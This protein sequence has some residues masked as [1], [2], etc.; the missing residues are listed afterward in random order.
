[1]N[2]GGLRIGFAGTPG[3]AATILRAL[4]THA[5]HSVTRVYS[6]P[7]RHSG[8]GRRLQPSAVAV[9]AREHGLNLQQPTRAAD[10]D[11]TGLAHLD[12]LAVAAF[13]LLLP[14]A[15]L[16]AP[17]LGCINVHASLLP[18]W[19]GAAP[20]QRAILAGD[21]CTGISIMQM[22]EGLDTG[23]VLL[24]K[25]CAIGADESAGQ[26]QERL[27]L[28]GAECLIEALAALAADTARRTPQDATAASYARKIRK[29]E[30]VIDWTMDAEQ[31]A[32]QVRA[33]NPVPIASTRLAGLELRIWEAQPVPRTENVPPGTLLRGD[34]SG[35][36]V[37][38][39]SGAVRITRLQLPGRRPVTAADFLNAHPDWRAAAAP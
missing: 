34:R 1:M 39:G 27:A 4:L 10:I 31:I 5:Q 33:F 22:D 15:L 35:I 8:R 6:L 19:R 9:L 11:A 2:P 36:D 7:D 13:G 12:V 38:A 16:H 37:A 23:D 18:R 20:I 30:A 32:R 21:A 25:S 14:A 17:R 3:F 24:Q 29:D 26:L 28:L